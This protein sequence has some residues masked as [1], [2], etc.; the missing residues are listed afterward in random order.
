M[1]TTDPHLVDAELES[2]GYLIIKDPEIA[3]LAAGAH[4]EYY[5]WFKTSTLHAPRESFHYSSLIDNPWRK[6]TIGSGNGL[7]EAYAQNLQTT[8]FHFDHPSFPALGS[9]FKTMTSLRN[10]LMG[11][12]AGFGSDPER[13]RFWDACR[14]H[15]Y[16]RGGGFMSVHRDT[17]FPQIID[18][19]IGKPYY[20][21]CVLLSRKSVEFSTGGGVIIDTSDNKVDVETAGG[22]GA[23]VLFDGRARHAVEDVDLDTIIDFNRPDGRLAAF[24]NLY[25]VR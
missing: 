14:I 12:P 11:V 17:Y 13:D 4:D 2:R 24:V 19:Q 7:G 10:T 18:A 22:F 23:L 8:Y 20:Q 9:L 1:T 3:A 25:A 21:L 16:P 5:R 6:L 15:H